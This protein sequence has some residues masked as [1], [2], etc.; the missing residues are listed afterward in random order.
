LPTQ[1]PAHPPPASTTAARSPVLAPTRLEFSLHLVVGSI[2]AVLAW[3][4]EEGELRR[5]TE[6]K[7]K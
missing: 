5:W 6:K 4:D 2:F 7:R 3:S 1:T